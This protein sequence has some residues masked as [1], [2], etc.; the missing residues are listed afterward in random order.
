MERIIIGEYHDE[1]YNDITGDNDGLLRM[2]K[3]ES[4]QES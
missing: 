4:Q 1:L 2:M 3:N